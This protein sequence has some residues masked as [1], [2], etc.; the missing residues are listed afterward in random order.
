M[1][2]RLTNAF[3][4]KISIV[5]KAKDVFE[6]IQKKF[7]KHFIFTGISEGKDYKDFN[8]RGEAFNRYAQNY[9]NEY[10]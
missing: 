1:H 5:S 7:S 2:R 8:E 3:L 9:I 10:K 4:I 6:F